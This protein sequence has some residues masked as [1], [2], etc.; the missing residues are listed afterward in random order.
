MDIQLAATRKSIVPLKLSLYLLQNGEMGY[1]FTLPDGGISDIYNNYQIGEVINEL[2]ILMQSVKGYSY[3]V[4]EVNLENAGMAIYRNYTSLAFSEK[5]R[6][7][8]MI[9]R[10][11]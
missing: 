9:E 5:N 1:R 3:V 8:L 11:L 10:G 4:T 7:E 2:K 6:F